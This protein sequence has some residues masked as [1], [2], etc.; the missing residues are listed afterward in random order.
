[1]SSYKFFFVEKNGIFIPIGSWSRSTEVYQAVRAPYEKITLA[2]EP[3]KE[4]IDEL[5]RK[6]KDYLSYIEE[7][8]KI[9]SDIYKIENVSLSEKID[10]INDYRIE[11]QNVSESIEKINFAID[12]LNFILNIRDPYEKVEVY[13]GEEISEPTLEDIEK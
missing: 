3:I 10:N 7:T 11:I 12:N 5:K 4:G 1:M 13:V 2:K 6:K 8:E 9:I